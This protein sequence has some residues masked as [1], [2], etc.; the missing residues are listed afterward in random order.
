MKIKATFIKNANDFVKNIKKR[1][2]IAKICQKPKKEI[3]KGD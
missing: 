1:L 3:Y 2:I